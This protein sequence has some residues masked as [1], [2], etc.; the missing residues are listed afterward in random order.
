MSGSLYYGIPPDK[1]QI[2]QFCKFSKFVKSAILNFENAKKRNFQ[3]VG[4]K[5]FVVI[6]AKHVKSSNTQYFFLKI[7]LE[8]QRMT[9]IGLIL[10]YVYYRKVQSS[11]LDEKNYFLL[12]VKG[13]KKQ[14]GQYWT[15][16]KICMKELQFNMNR[17]VEFDFGGSL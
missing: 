7:D 17:L 8:E 10:I 14:R 16:L 1:F 15:I 5:L 9:N 3:L 2:F 6:K 12:V 4:P 11:T 13:L